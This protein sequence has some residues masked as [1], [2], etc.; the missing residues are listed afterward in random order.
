MKNL[1]FTNFFV[2][3]L[4]I[5]ITRVSSGSELTIQMI[6]NNTN[7]VVAESKVTTS[8]DIATGK[9]SLN[10]K[11]SGEYLNYKDASWNAEVKFKKEDDLLFTTQSNGSVYNDDLNNPE[12]TYQRTYDYDK[13]KIFYTKTFKNDK[14]KKYTLPLKGLTTDSYSIM[15]AISPL[16]ERWEKD[17][18]SLDFYF[19]STRPRLIHLKL[20]YIKDALIKEGKNEIPVHQFRLLPRLGV[21]NILLK[22]ILP[23]YYVY[24]GT[25]KPHKWYRYRTSAVSGAKKGTELIK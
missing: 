19:L 2:F 6:K 1:S 4:F 21:F 25:E 15:H 5:C 20:H 14:K 22:K 10:L 18:T 9:L 8:Y 12:I 7:A 16:V 13:K 24:Y 11:G 3:I 17:G 23:K